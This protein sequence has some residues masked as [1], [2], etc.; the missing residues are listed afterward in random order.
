MICSTGTRQLLEVLHRINGILIICTGIQCQSVRFNYSPLFADACALLVGP[1]DATRYNF[2]RITCPLDNNIAVV[3]LFNN[4]TCKIYFA[5]FT[6]IDKFPSGFYLSIC[7]T[8]CDGENYIFV[9]CRV[10][11]RLHDFGCVEIIICHIGINQFRPNHKAKQRRNQR[12]SNNATNQLLGETALLIIACRTIIVCTNIRWRTAT[13][14]TANACIRGCIGRAT[15][16]RCNRR[17]KV[18]LLQAFALCRGKCTAETLVRRTPRAGA[19]A[20]MIFV[21]TNV[22]ALLEA[23]L[24]S[25][26]GIIPSFRR[27]T[28]CRRCMSLHKC[29]QKQL[30]D[31][32]GKNIGRRCKF[33]NLLAGNIL[34]EGTLTLE[35]AVRSIRNRHG[36][37]RRNNSAGKGM[38]AVHQQLED[39]YR[40]SKVIGCLAE[41]GKR[42]IGKTV[43][44]LLLDFNRKIL[45]HTD[46]AA[47]GIAAV[48]DMVGVGINKGDMTRIGIDTDILG[49]K[50]TANVTC[51][52]YCIQHYT[53]VLCNSDLIAPSHFGVLGRRTVLINNIQ[54]FVQLELAHNET[55]EFIVII[56][57]VQGPSNLIK[58]ILLRRSNNHLKQFSFVVG[59]Y[60]TRFI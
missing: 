31:L 59:R 18:R 36:V 22:F 29:E 19:L 15:G 17:R 10:T 35:N 25:F 44:H 12:N 58:N 21:M 49:V 55:N 47:I 13:S 6:V 43:M 7:R 39:M 41:G 5:V 48:S 33:G 60:F 11:I 9:L 26:K 30:L 4:F 16:R 20:V 57:H 46:I 34:E 27:R 32:L 28:S 54:I 53:K 42:C 40:Q 8:F 56:K 1:S 38:H 45:R 3:L 2:H 37:L 24:K 14:C 23:L 52:V 50:V 51:F